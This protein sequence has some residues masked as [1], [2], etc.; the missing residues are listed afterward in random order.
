[1]PPS[2]LDILHRDKG[3]RRIVFGLM[4]QSVMYSLSPGERLRQPYRS[5]QETI[6]AVIS[7]E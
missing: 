7:V 6:S 2:M 5:R 1:M 3:G 4:L